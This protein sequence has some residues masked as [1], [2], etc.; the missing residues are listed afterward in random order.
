MERSAIPWSSRREPLRS[1]EPN[2]EL[3]LADQRR[4][5]IHFRRGSLRTEQSYLGLIRRF[6]VWSGKRHPQ[7]F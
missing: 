3:K 5:V 2:R 6:I 1:I 4:E 7:A